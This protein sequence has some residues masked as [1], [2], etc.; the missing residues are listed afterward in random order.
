LLLPHLPPI[1]TIAEIAR[2]LRRSPMHVYTLIHDGD[3]RAVRMTSSK[4]K[5]SSRESYVVLADDLRDFI[6]R[7][8]AG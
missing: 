4:R 8:R 1:L 3:L 2:E 6:E 7:R 5:K